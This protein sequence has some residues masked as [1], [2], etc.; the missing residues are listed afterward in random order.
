MSAR[1]L[2]GAH[3]PAA[4]EE[5]WETVA[6]ECLGLSDTAPDS[7]CGCRRRRRVRT[8]VCHSTRCGIRE[9]RNDDLAFIVGH[10]LRELVALAERD[11]DADTARRSLDGVVERLPLP[12]RRNPVNVNGQQ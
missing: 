4:S 2:L 7:T 1:R 3:L 11:A 10:I 6:G 8:A 9:E 5:R 12:A